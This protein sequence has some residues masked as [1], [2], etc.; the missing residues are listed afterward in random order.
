MGKTGTLNPLVDNRDVKGIATIL[1]STLQGQKT[2]GKFGTTVEV[3][4]RSTDNVALPDTAEGIGA[5]RFD[6][7]P[8]AKLDF[9][10]RYQDDFLQQVGGAAAT[11]GTRRQTAVGV[12]AQLSARVTAKAELINAEMGDGALVGLTTRV[13]ERTM[14]YGTYAM[15]PDHTGAMTG[16]LTAGAATALGDRT[17]LYTE[18]QF[19]TSDREVSSSTVAGLNTKVTDRLTTGVNFERTRLNG[20]GTNP[21]TLRQAASLSASYAQ[22]WF[23]I[24]SKLELRHDEA[25]SPGLPAPPTD[26]DQ[27][28]ASSALEVKLSRDF[29]WSAKSWPC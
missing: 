22:A 7:R 28:L 27:W 19:K 4:Y 8:A 21:D 16:V 20:T 3:R 26:R 10:T 17:R 13:D 6:Y 9:Y 25:P 29:T 18:E 24:F 15:S 1:T 5:I 2:F 14:L 12:D 11:T 23:K